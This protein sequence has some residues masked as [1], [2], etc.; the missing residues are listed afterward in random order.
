MVDVAEIV[1][2]I[3]V[4]LEG[5]SVFEFLEQQTAS[6]V[7]AESLGVVEN[8]RDGVVIGYELSRLIEG[9]AIEG[10]TLGNEYRTLLLGIFLALSGTAV[11]ERFLTSGKQQ[12]SCK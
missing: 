6:V 8:T 4:E 9:H 2:G 12:Q 7:L 3:L 11:L 10:N 5:S 1:T